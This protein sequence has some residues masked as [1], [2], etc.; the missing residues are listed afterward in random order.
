[1]P[2]GLFYTVPSQCALKYFPSGITNINAG[3]Q[4]AQGLGCAIFTYI[5]FYC[6]NHYNHEIILS[7]TST[8]DPNAFE[9]SGTLMAIGVMMVM[10][11]GFVAWH[12]RY[13]KRTN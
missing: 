7:N 8:F 3:M 12:I 5:I 10:A 1:M 6:T 13:P 2:T 4:G 9:I 11:A